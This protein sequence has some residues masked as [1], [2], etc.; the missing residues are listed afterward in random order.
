MAK[1]RFIGG[2]PRSLTVTFA[3]GLL[4][5]CGSW[6]AGAFRHLWAQKTSGGVFTYPIQFKGGNTWY[7]PPAIGWYIDLSFVAHFV[8]LLVLALICYRHRN[9]FARIDNSTGARA[10][11]P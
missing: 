5:L 2:P 11:E 9:S 4:N 1:Y 8:I 3:V 7:F 6:I 10:S